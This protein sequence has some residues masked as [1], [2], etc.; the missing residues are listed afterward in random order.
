MDSSGASNKELFQRAG[1]NYIVF[2]QGDASL[3]THFAI[4][5]KAHTVVPTSL[6][7]SAAL[8]PN[9]DERRS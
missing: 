5:W 6:A 1:P 3:V 9:D 2:Q 7:N 4:P 8:P